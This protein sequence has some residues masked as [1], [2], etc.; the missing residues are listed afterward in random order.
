M[1]RMKLAIDKKGR[2]NVKIPA[3]LRDK[4]GL[5][6]GDFVDVDTDGTKIIIY[7]DKETQ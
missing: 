4:F 1:S 5:K 2:T 3:F 6:N 7:V